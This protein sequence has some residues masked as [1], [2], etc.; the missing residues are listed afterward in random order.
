MKIAQV[1]GKEWKKEVC[2]YLVA[3]KLTPHATTGVQLLFGRK[4]RTKLPELREESTEM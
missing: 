3:Y 1:E 4:M 2:N